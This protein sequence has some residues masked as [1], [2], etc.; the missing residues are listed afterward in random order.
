MVSDMQML[1]RANFLSQY[2]NDPLC[3]PLEVR[4]RMMDAARIEGADKILVKQVPQPPPDPAIELAKM[5]LQNEHMKVVSQ[6]RK[7][8]VEEILIRRRRS[9]SLRRPTR[10]WD[11]LNRMD[12]DA[13]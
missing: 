4:R 6:A 8:R 7:D 1:G 3:D 10:R 9:T 11:R 5:Q 13:A 2:Q 12:H